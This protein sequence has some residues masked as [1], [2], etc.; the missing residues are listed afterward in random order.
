MGK[1]ADILSSLEFLNDVNILTSRETNIA[2][3]AVNKDLQKPN[4]RIMKLS[5]TPTRNLS[6]HNLEL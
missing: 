6:C 3:F 2:G 4:Q 5:W 1:P